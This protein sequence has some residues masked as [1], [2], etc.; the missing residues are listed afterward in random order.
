MPIFSLMK[1]VVTATRFFVCCKKIVMW[2]AM[3][4]VIEEYVQRIKQIKLVFQNGMETLHGSHIFARI[5]R[6]Y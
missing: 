3:E 6:Y 5:N 2:M 4:G 1:R